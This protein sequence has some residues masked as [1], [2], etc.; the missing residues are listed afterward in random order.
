M[1]SSAVGRLEYGE[2]RCHAGCY[3]VTAPGVPHWLPSRVHTACTADIHPL[4][5]HPR[6][7]AGLSEQLVALYTARLMERGRMPLVGG[8]GLGEGTG[9]AALRHCRRGGRAGLAK[10]GGG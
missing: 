4:H 2:E 1:H 7:I 10:Q 3:R 9:T 6:S 8:Q 5:C